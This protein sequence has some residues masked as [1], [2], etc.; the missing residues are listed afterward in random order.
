MFVGGVAVFTVASALC[1]LAPNPD[2]LI[3][4]RLLQGVGAAMISPTVLALIG[5]M[6]TGAERTKAIGAYATVMGGAAASGQLVGGVLLH[7]DVAGLGWRS[8]FLVNVPIGLVALAGAGNVPESKADGRPRIDLA[9]LTLL[10]AAVTA[11][12]LPLVQGRSAGWPLWTFLSLAAAPVLVAL[13]GVR[14]R[15]EVTRGHAPLLDPRLLREPTIATGLA[16]QLVFWCGQASYFFVLAL[17]LQMGRG[18]S[19]LES[20][21]AFTLVA[22]PYVV[23]S[24]RAPRLV[25]RYGR[26][27]V[28]AGALVMVAGHALTVL[29]SLEIGA[30]GS[31][32]AL[33]PGMVLAGAGMGMCL[34]P[35][36]ATV[37]STLE[38]QHAG[39]VSGMLS[40]VQ[41]VGNAIGV[42]VIGLV[43]FGEQDHG[44]P[45]AFEWS[46]VTLTL[47]LVA[48]AGLARLLPAGRNHP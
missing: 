24:G 31:V 19:A 11:L 6:Y 38:P 34:A 7:L 32:L 44:L 21:A 28:V 46:M 29:G 36:T 33:A 40:T 26:T 2:T 35:I 17:Y 20:G 4:A 47:L 10:T 39:S 13:L 25:A 5:V 8:I 42:A 14:Q 27:T 16:T 22:V 37:L 30:G 43:F 45:T 12:M 23:T 15:S 41:Q 48:V 3:A 1:G 9:S 18:L